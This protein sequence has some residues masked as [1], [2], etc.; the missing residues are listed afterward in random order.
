MSY[1][2]ADAYTIN[3]ATFGAGAWQIDA[4]WYDTKGNVVRTL[5]EDAV[6]ATL[7]DP[8][9]SQAQVDDLSTQTFYNSDTTDASGKTILPAG[10]RVE[11]T[12]GPARDVML[13]NGSTARVRPHS[14]T[15]YDEGAPNSGLNAATGQPYS[16][17]TT[18]VSDAVTTLSLIH[19]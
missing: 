16:L 18:V 12:F 4:T 11:Q 17:A 1:I 6:N 15:I 14:R 2:N 3:T 5:D 19:I 10:S 7:A 13:N 8:S 9:M